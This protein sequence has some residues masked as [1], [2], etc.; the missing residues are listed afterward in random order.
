MSATLLVAED[1]TP[2]NG[3]QVPFGGFFR[4]PNE[5]L[6]VTVR[7]VSDERVHPGRFEALQL[8]CGV[9]GHRTPWGLGCEGC[10]QK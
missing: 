2:V 7:L 4:A 1:V 5:I 9:H 3:G 6:G 10:Q 8:V